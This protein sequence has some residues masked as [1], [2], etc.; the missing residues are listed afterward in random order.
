MTAPRRPTPALLLG[1]GPR[2]EAAR[3]RRRPHRPCRQ[4]RRRRRLCP[5]TAATARR[6]I[7]AT[8]RRRRT[9]AVLQASGPRA[10]AAL[11]RLRR[12]RRP[13]TAA[14]APRLIS[15]IAP[16]RQT[17]APASG[18]SATAAWSFRR[19]PRPPSLRMSAAMTRPS[20]AATAI[21]P[22]P[23]ALA[24]V[25]SGRPVAT[26]AWLSTRRPRHRSQRL[27]T[28]TA[29]TTSPSRI[30][31]IA[32]WPSRRAP[33]ALAFGL[34]VA[35]VTTRETPTAPQTPMTMAATISAVPT[36][37]TAITTRRRALQSQ[38]PSRTR[39]RPHTLTYMYC[40]CLLLGFSA[41]PWFPPATIPP[42]GSWIS[43][44]ACALRALPPPNPSPPP[45]PNAGTVTAVFRAVCPASNYNGTFVSN[46]LID[47]FAN[48]AAVADVF[49]T[50]DLV[51]LCSSS[52][53]ALIQTSPPLNTMHP[54]HMPPMRAPH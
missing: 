51:D 18:P 41:F 40:K 47:N 9:P 13:P 17:P 42:P 8:A 25:V 15:A 27:W 45:P 7:S 29:A 2:A 50:Y 46:N 53:C 35:D 24:L 12:H 44:C 37:A 4:L 33:Q 43:G 39:S 30:R 52:V 48:L 6:P 23:S 49:I 11:P 22:L 20:I 5:P 1:S 38:V 14:T 19:P 54:T 36:S 21:A 31:A 34:R 3:P 32:P 26:A 16:Q 28:T 10:E